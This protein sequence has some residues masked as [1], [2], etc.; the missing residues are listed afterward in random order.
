MLNANKNLISWQAITQAALDTEADIL[1]LQET[2]INWTADII[3]HIWQMLNKTPYQTTK[4]SHLISKETTTNNYQPGGMMTSVL[5]RW[6]AWVTNSGQD[7]T[8]LG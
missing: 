6:T 2:N 5:G 8:G 3:N 1:C 7:N 4:T